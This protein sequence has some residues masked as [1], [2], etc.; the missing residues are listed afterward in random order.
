M[1][2][3]M[4]HSGHGG[5]SPSGDTGAPPAS[6][7]YNINFQ[8][9]EAATA[10]AESELSFVVT[11]QAVGEPLESFELLHDRL[12]HLIIVDETLSYF[13]HVHP[14]LSDGAF[15]ISHTFPK[16][17]RYKLWAEAKPE[18]ASSVLA[19]FRLDV[20]AGNASQDSGPAPEPDAGYRVSLTPSGSAPMHQPVDLTFE[21]ADPDGKPV[22][23][24]E[25]L[26]AAGGHC[27]II[28]RDLRDFLHVH[29]MQDVDPDWRG[30]PQVEFMT[31]FHKPGSYRIWGQFQHRGS[32][33]TAGFAL[34]VAES[35]HH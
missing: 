31:T 23:D 33:I 19:A 28:S 27:V 12:M 35:H 11:E 8:V 20:K 34:D 7:P 2:P 15:R 9:T 4:E 25:P 32:L 13:D 6:G 21:I 24:L 10:D 3:N 5:H 16:A 30:G 17:G 26:M 14:T 29:P 18:G 22:T 1:E